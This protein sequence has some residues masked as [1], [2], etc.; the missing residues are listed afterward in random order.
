MA[1]SFVLR[2]LSG[3]RD[4]SGDGEVTLDR[5]TT[6]LE[7]FQMRKWW[8]PNGVAP[9]SKKSYVKVTRFS[10]ARGGPDYKLCVAC[11]KD[12]VLH[13][14]YD[15]NETFTFPVAR[16]VERVAV[17]SD[18]LSTLHVDYGDF[19]QPV[20]SCPATANVITGVPDLV[21]LGTMTIDVSSIG[22]QIRQGVATGN[23]V[24]SLDGDATIT[25][26]YT[27][28]W[29][30]SDGSAVFSAP[31]ALTTTVT[32]SAS[33]NQTLTCTATAVAG[34]PV[35]DGPTSAATTANQAV[36]AT[37]ALAT[38]GTL[39]TT[40]AFTASQSGQAATIT[41]TSSTGTS[42]T[43][44]YDSDGSGDLTAVNVTAGGSLWAVGDTV[45]VTEGAGT[46]GVG[47]G[48]VASIT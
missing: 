23:V 36:V 22:A 48:A 30:S 44:T 46:P 12:A 38:V 42:A 13:V 3:M 37:G 9:S 26:D 25:T 32:F 5:P 33:G 43:I 19:K 2:G 11:S 6:G 45:E 24:A 7:Q 20:R 29:T 4:V 31:T 18:D 39:A 17:F 1:D 41:A 28:A 10:I 27:V 14:E 21:T 40:T 15:G 8:G 16:G 35:D 34:R 47:T